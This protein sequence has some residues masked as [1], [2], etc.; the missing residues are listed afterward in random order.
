M[1]NPR[2]RRRIWCGRHRSGKAAEHRHQHRALAIIV[3]LVIGTILMASQRRP[4]PRARRART[5]VLGMLYR[6]LTWNGLVR[7]LLGTMQSR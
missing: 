1:L 3:F 6:E 4:S 7:A 2:S 5:L